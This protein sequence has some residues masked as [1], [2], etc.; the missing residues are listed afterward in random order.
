MVD[1]YPTEET[2]GVFTE[3]TEEIISSVVLSSLRPLPCSRREVL[4][5]RGFMRGEGSG[6]VKVTSSNIFLSKSNIALFL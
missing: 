3:S 4:R 6:G 5:L 1:F 2:I